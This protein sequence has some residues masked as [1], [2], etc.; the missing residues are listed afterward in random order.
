LKNNIKIIIDGVELDLKNEQYYLNRELLLADEIKAL[1]A[2][3]ADLQA[4]AR[5]DQEQIDELIAER[6]EFCQD[7]DSLSCANEKMQE[8]IAELEEENGLAQSKILDLEILLNTVQGII[9]RGL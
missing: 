1:R 5:E 4:G 6:I 9:E 7:L 3:I 8:E 2:E